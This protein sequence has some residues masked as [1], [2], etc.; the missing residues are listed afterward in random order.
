MHGVT[1]KV[2]KNGGLSYCKNWRGITL[3]SVTS[4]IFGILKERLKAGID[5]QLR[6][7]QAGFRSGRRTSV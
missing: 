3:L 6:K 7:E 4:K 5:K 1:I 2:P